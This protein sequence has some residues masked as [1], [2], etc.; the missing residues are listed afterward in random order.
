MLQLHNGQILEAGD[1]TTNARTAIGIDQP[2]KLLFLAIAERISLPRMLHVLAN[3]GA[4]D[5]FL[6]DGGDSSAMGIGRGST[7]IPAAVLLGGGR[8]VATYIGVRALPC[9]S[10]VGFCD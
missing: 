10:A 4:K 1:S 6:L 8:P 7:R 5:G 2:R 3:L 9:R